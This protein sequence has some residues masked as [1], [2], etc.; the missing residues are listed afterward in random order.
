MSFKFTIDTEVEEAVSEALATKAAL[1]EVVRALAQENRA[2]RQHA[3]EVVLGVALKEPKKLMPFTAEILDSLERPESMTRYNI[4][5][6]ID[7]LQK[8]DKDLIVESIDI[9]EEHLYDPS[10][11]N[12]RGSA[13]SV[14]ANYGAVS[15][16]RSEQV[17]PMLEGALRVLHGKAELPNIISH[18]IIMLEGEAT[19]IVHQN[20]ADIFKYDCKSNDLGLRKRA[21]YICEMAGVDWEEVFRK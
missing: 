17:W 14:I 11:A 8:L 13:F 18:L 15:G 2:L 5:Q 16:E 6:A 1:T 10:S 19:P 12:V 3:A 20:A 7:E 4:L 21:R 9:I